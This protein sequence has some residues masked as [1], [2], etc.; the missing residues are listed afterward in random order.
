VPKRDL[1][2]FL[3]DAKREFPASFEGEEYARQ[4]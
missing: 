1:E 2:S 4:R 3:K